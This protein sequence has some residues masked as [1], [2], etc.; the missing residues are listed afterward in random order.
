[1]RNRRNYYRILHVDRDAPAAVIQASYRTLMH[2][3]RVHPDLGG[4][5]GEAALV[6]EAFATLG[7]PARRAAYDVQL[8]R[9]SLH[10]SA[11]PAK[12]AASPTQPKSQA[13]KTVCGFCGA[14]HLGAQPT[15]PDASCARC[16][17][18]LSPPPR[19]DAGDRSRRK[20]ERLPRDLPVTFRRAESRDVVWHGSMKDISLQ[21]MRLVT[22]LRLS[23]GERLLIENSFCTTV[24]VVKSTRRNP[25]LQGGAWESGVELLT[26]RLVQ[27]QGRL[28]SLLA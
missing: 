14:P 28:I 26:I 17:S 22:P 19:Q 27:D 2:R 3:L 15:R 12:P 10:R 6:N 13:K 23:A 24:A 11:G 5:E 20:M 4:D 1:M 7:D 9:T 8:G 18:P 16:R 21:G 25:A